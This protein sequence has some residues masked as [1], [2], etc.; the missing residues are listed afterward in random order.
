M[1]SEFI[2]DLLAVAERLTVAAADGERREVSQALDQLRAVALEVGNAWSGSPIGYHARVYHADFAKP[3]ANAHWSSEWGAQ[4]AFSNPTYGDWQLHSHDAVV[5]E[6]RRRAGDPDLTQPESA[7]NEAKK[8]FRE[9][10]SEVVS[11]LTAF[12]SERPDELIDALK[13]R[14]EKI[15]VPSADEYARAALPSGE[16]MSRDMKAMTEGLRVAPHFAVMAEMLA[17][18]SPFSSCAE[19]ADVARQAAAHLVRIRHARQAV[20]SLQGKAVFIGHGGSPLWRELKDFIQDRLG[21]SWEEFNRVPI[22]GV[23]NI[24]RLAEMLDASGVAFLVLTA[25]DER[26]DGTVVA[27]QNVVHEAGLFQGRLGFTRAIIVLEEGCEPFSN[28]EGL[29]QI[30]FPAGQIA[31]AFEEVRMVLEREGLLV[32]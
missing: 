14:A 5:E 11:I 22:A 8:V 9:A 17:L 25:E 19:L 24:A 28:I 31:A 12:T 3:P 26:V 23:T 30:R 1:A 32:S 27:R 2:D 21:L 16:F 10:R 13:A 7:A 18:R 15:T 4:E 29:G 20:A 6:I